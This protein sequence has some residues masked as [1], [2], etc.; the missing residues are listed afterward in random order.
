MIY[1]GEVRILSR[2]PENHLLPAGFQLFVGNPFF[3]VTKHDGTG[4][5]W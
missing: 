3:Y 2:V 1:K 5:G 4:A